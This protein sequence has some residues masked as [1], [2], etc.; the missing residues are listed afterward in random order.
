VGISTSGGNVPLDYVVQNVLYIRELCDDKSPV[1]RGAS[2]PLSRV[3]GTADFIHGKDGLGDIGLDLT[4]RVC[5]D[6]LASDQL[7]KSILTHP[8]EIE[9]VCLGPLTNI[10]LAERQHPGILDLAK[11]HYNDRMGYNAV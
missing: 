9:L 11:R 8:G 10:A 3:L 2:Q 6:G 1:Y 5:D 7:I 4:G